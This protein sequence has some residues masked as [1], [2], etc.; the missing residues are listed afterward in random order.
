MFGLGTV[1]V[2]GVGASVDPMLDIAD[3]I[4]PRQAVFRQKDA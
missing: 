4:G 1:V 3:P 2:R